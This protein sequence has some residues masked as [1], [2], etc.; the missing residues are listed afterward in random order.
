MPKPT[1]TDLRAELERCHR[2][3]TSSKNFAA[4]TV[5]LELCAELDTFPTWVHHAVD[6]IIVGEIEEGVGDVGRWYRTNRRDL[7]D[8][9]RADVIRRA[10]AHGFT[11][12]EASAFAADYLAPTP[13]GGATA[14][15]MMKSWRRFHIRGDEIGALDRFYV[16]APGRGLE[17]FRPSPEHAAAVREKFAQRVKRA[18]RWI[19]DSS[20]EPT[21]TPRSTGNKRRRRVPQGT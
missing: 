14:A 19:S 7:I 20:M 5:A 21:P 2:R 12:E 9:V 4:L 3:F 11:W 6:Q 1:R 15:A 13:A 16:T 17:E 10:R 18:G 8:Y